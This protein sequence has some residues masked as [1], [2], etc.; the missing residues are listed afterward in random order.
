MTE[1]VITATYNMPY[2]PD[3]YF[4][5]EKSVRKLYRGGARR[6]AEKF[7]QTESALD[8][9]H[10]YGQNIVTGFNETPTLDLSPVYIRLAG[11]EGAFLLDAASY[12]WGSEGMVVSSDL[13]LL[14][15]GGYDGASAPATSWLRLPVAP[16]TIGPAS[17]TTIESS[18][19]KANS[20]NIPGGFDARNPGPTLA[21]LPTNG[22]DVFREWKSNTQLVPPA[23]VLEQFAVAAGP[24][25]IL[26]EFEYSLTL[27]TETISLATG[28]AVD[29]QEYTMADAVPLASIVYSQSTVYS[30]N[31]AADVASM[32]NGEVGGTA[33]GT[34]FA[35]DVL[36][37]VQMDF[38]VTCDIDRLI[39]GTATGDMPGGWTKGNTENCDIQYSLNGTTWTTYGTTGTFAA[40]GIYQL[41]VDFL[42][43]Y[44]RI[45]LLGDYLGM[46]ELYAL[47][48][49]QPLP[50][51]ME[52]AAIA[53]GPAIDAEDPAT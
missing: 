45:A 16:A 42:A 31:T 25:I 26:R 6:A 41:P 2:A 43:R 27:P 47:A 24:Q 1:P 22:T 5:Y 49:G 38:G 3:D 36:S 40:E 52:T 7:G 37:W 51:V 9:G 18:P 48:V 32:Q 19:V 39:I 23:L 13:M 11:I 44:V 28:P 15:V 34:D 30:S 4:Y 8:V 17:G 33:T 46:S 14:G 53:T 10:A 50:V 35:A 20:I 12:A 21:Q 29:S